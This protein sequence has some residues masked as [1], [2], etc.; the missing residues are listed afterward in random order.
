[1]VSARFA[2]EAGDQVEA[3]SMINEIVAWRRA[4]QPG[5]RNAGS[6]FV[7]PS[8]GEGSAG[9]LIDGAGLRGHRIG[10]ARVS[11][12]HANFI[13]ADDGC[14]ADDIIGV[15]RHV[16]Q[17][18]ATVSGLMLR[19]EVQLLGFDDEVARTF[20]DP[21]HDSPDRRASRERLGRILG[22]SP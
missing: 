9:A 5:G 11:E 18:V 4:N 17:T 16:Q 8:P 3:E 1:M 20:S 19:S 22:E 7:N 13:Q 2:T 6:V 14:T 21:R 12:K 10:G 15:L